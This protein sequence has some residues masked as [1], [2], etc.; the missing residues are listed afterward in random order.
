MHA[1]VSVWLAGGMPK[2]HRGGRRGAKGHQRMLQADIYIS[3]TNRPSHDQWR[4]E[5]PD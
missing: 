2:G 4:S 3:D 1:H 5:K